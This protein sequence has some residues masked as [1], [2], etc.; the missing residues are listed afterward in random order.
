MCCI[1][2]YCI[3]VLCSFPAVVSLL[4]ITLMFL[5]LEVKGA[6]ALNLG[7]VTESAGQF[8]VYDWLKGLKSDIM[9]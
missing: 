3:Y 6:N 8:G 1:V 7:A 2:S 9:R 5:F 4:T